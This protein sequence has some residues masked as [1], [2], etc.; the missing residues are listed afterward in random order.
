MDIEKLLQTREDCKAMM[1]Y[2]LERFVYEHGVRYDKFFANEH[3]I[4]EDDGHTIVKVLDVSHSGCFFPLPLKVND[5]EGTKYDDEDTLRNSFDLYCFW[6]FYIER[7]KEG[8][9]TLMYYMFYND[10]VNWDDENSE[11]DHSP[12][13]SLSLAQLDYILTALKQIYKDNKT[14]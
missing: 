8:H 1:L 4:Y 12:A 11:P 7:D 9:N 5:Y 10:G 13:E 14:E 2:A 3:G 6:S